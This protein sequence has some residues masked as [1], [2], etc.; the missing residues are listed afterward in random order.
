MPSGGDLVVATGYEEA[1]DRVCI[2]VRDTGSGIQDSDRNRVFEPFFTTKEVGKGT[3]L[4][5]SICYKI[6]E[7]HQ[8]SIEFETALGKGT[9]FRIY[10]PAHGKPAWTD[11]PVDQENGEQGAKKVSIG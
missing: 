5:L 6:I 9:T 11:E 1:M 2:A 10:L 7:N 8:G 4:G 3:G